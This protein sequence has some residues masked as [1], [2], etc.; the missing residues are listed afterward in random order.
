MTEETAPSGDAAASDTVPAAPPSNPAADEAAKTAAD[1]KPG[2]PYQ[3]Q[4]NSTNTSNNISILS[5]LHFNNGSLSTSPTIP[6]CLLLSE[7]M[8]RHV[9]VFQK[10]AP[11]Y[12]RLNAN[13]RDQVETY[14]S[15]P[16]GWRRRPNTRRIDIDFGSANNA[17]EGG[18]SNNTTDVDAKLRAAFALRESKE[19]E[20]RDLV[21]ATLKA[22]NV[23]SRRGWGFSLGEG[24]AAAAGQY[25]GLLPP[26]EDAASRKKRLEHI[27]KQLKDEEKGADERKK[28]KKIA[29]K[30]KELILNPKSAEKIVE[31]SQNQVSP[32]ISSIGYLQDSSGVKRKRAD[33]ELDQ[34]L[35]IEE[36]K[37]REKILRERIKREEAEHKRLIK[38]ERE[39]EERRERALDTPRDALHRLYE[40]IYTA[41]WDLEFPE[42]GNTNPFRVVIDKNTCAA[43]GVPDYC[44]VI[45]KPMNLTY[46]QNKVNK[47]SY[48]SLQEFLEDVDLIV[49]NALK[50]NPDPNN[51]VHIAAKGLRKTF[52]KVAKPLVQSLTKGLAAT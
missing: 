15:T 18:D 1:N 9:A 31:K 16:A 52:K 50:Y 27:A 21:N 32:Q 45:E 14:G 46:I 3:W 38:K 42:V 23:K 22:E 20:Q 12:R 44:D 24:G 4:L 49:R 36:A 28:W 19:H 30:A 11:L 26:L 8:P 13:L 43:M 41:L 33:T 7:S 2:A 48:D 6:C 35:Q 39:E 34:Q 17:S 25:A 40:P 51:P 37:K 47:K 5:S 29:K 10:L